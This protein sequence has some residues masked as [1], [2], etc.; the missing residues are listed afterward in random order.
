MKIFS[1][2]DTHLKQ[3]H[4]QE[5]SERYGRDSIVII[6]RSNL[7]FLKKIAIHIFLWIITYLLFIFGIYMRMGIDITLRYGIRIWLVFLLTFFI[8]ATENYID[9]S[10]NYA[11]FTPQE[12]ILVEQLWFFKRTI[13]SLDTKKI[14]SISIKKS[15]FIYSLFDDGLLTIF[16]EGSNTHGMGEIVFKYVHKPEQVKDNIQHIISISTEQHHEPILYH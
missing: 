5:F 10:M 6:T 12:A 16:N 1:S 2:F 14:K 13:K 9:Y 8:I 11:I 7:Y 3:N 4:I 15:N